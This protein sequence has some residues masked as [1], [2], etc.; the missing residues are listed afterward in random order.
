MVVLFSDTPSSSA[1]KPQRSAVREAEQQRSELAESSELLDDADDVGDNGDDVDDDLQ[2]TDGKGG[3]NKGSAGTIF[4]ITTKKRR[5]S[6]G[7]A[8]ASCSDSYGLATYWYSALKSVESSILETMIASSRG[9]AQQAA[10]ASLQRQADG[11]YAV[12]SNS[13]LKYK[14]AALFMVSSTPKQ[15]LGPPASTSAAPDFPADA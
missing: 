8:S 1:K 9:S 13:S 11:E 5:A 12:C 7:L 6:R 14:A 10:Q 3:S 2:Y 15:Q 4:G